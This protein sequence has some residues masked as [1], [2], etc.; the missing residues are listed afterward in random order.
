MSKPIKLWL[1]G[2]ALV[3]HFKKW[4]T[5]CW[6]LHASLTYQEG[7]ATCTCSLLKCSSLPV[8]WDVHYFCM[9]AE[10]VGRHGKTSLGGQGIVA[11]QAFLATLS[12]QPWFRGRHAASGA[13][14]RADFGNLR[15]LFFPLSLQDAKLLNLPRDFKAT[16]LL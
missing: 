15:K 8:L 13:G 9:L 4:D 5:H 16:D 11:S 2:F 1:E 10:A 14:L 6:R 12:L 3:L 7:K